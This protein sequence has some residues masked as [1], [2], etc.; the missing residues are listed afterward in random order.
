[1]AGT[2]ERPALQAPELHR[3]DDRWFIYYAAD[4]GRNRNHRVWVLVTADDDPAGPYRS[5]G[6]IQTGGWSIDATVPT[7]LADERFLLWSGWEGTVKGV[8]NLYIAPLA[9]PVTLAGPRVLLTQPT[10]GW[11]QRG[12]C[13]CE[14]PAVLRRA[15]LTCVVYSASA[16]WTVCSCLGMLVNDSGD[17]LNPAAW[18]KVG[19]GSRELRRCGASAMPVSSPRREAG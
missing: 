8:Q 16:S 13:I 3:F 12:G 18:K 19:P 14:G 17:Y 5:G 4:D 6:M 1:M 10:E 2:G 15:G 7:S 9:D 11:E